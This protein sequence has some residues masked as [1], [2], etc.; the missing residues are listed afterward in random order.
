MPG[1]SS[2]IHGLFFILRKLLVLDIIINLRGVTVILVAFDTPLGPALLPKTSFAQLVEEYQL[3][4]SRKTPRLSV[5]R[6][7]NF[8]IV[9]GI[10]K[11]NWGEKQNDCW[12]FFQNLSFRHFKCVRE[13]IR[14]VRACVHVLECSVVRSMTQA[15]L[16][17]C[18]C[19]YYVVDPVTSK[20]LPMGRKKTGYIIIQGVIWVSRRVAGVHY[21]IS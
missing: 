11:I 20:W 16:P 9:S 8:N 13:V 21:S 19:A 5:W 12:I 17:D 3:M 15:C 1:F 6:R 10:L 18:Q 4:C 2:I 14:H 7:N